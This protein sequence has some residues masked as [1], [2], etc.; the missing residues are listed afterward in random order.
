[1]QRRKHPQPV[2]QVLQ[3]RQQLEPKQGQEP[4]RALVLQEAV[5]EEEQ[6]H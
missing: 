1:M 2:L 3:K 5:G 6:F 4:V